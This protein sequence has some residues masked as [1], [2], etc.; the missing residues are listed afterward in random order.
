MTKGE[1][2]TSR[3]LMIPFLAIHAK[4][5]ENMSPK[6]KDRTTYFKTLVLNIINWLSYYVQKGRESSIS[7]WYIKTLWTLRGGFHLGGVLFSQRRGI[8][9]KGRKFQ[10]L[11][12]LCKILL[13][14]L[15]LFA[16]RTLKKIYK[17]VCKN[18]TCGAGVVQNVK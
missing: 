2:R 4:G 5:G 7:K 11:K 1:D 13:I 15:W 16:K 17:I 10:I 8:W 9:N 14:Y 18:K 12:M 6:Q 3:A